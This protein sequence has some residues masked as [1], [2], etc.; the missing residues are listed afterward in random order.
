M[1]TQTDDHLS[2]RWGNLRRILERNGPFCHPNFTASPDILEFL[3][4]SCKILVI[5][6]LLL[7]NTDFVGRA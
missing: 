3:M 6:E 7:Q 4:T 1:D 5:G 2:K